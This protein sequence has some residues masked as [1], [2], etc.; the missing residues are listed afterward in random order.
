MD[1]NTN[2]MEKTN[3]Q[4]TKNLTALVIIFV[5]LFAGSLFVDLVQLVLGRGFSRTAVKEYD[6][7]ETGGRTWVA[8]NEP[9]VIA[10]IITNRNCATCDPSE[11]LTWLRRVI[12]TLEALPVEDDSDLG[13][14]LIERFE[15]MSLPAFIFSDRITDTDFYSQAGSLFRVEG[16][17]YFFDMGKIGLP[18]GCYINNMSTCQ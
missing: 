5:G 17:K 9:K 3:E 18:A 8:Y 11:A 7:L 13:K 6:L 1:V 12:P 15:I 4:R 14:F 2:Q 16:E 10:Q